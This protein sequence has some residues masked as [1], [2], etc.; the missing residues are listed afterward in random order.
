MGIY[1]KMLIVLLA[2]MLVLCLPMATAAAGHF[3]LRSADFTN[4]GVIPAVHGGLL[5]PCAASKTTKQTHK[6]LMPTLSWS[7]APTGTR[8]FALLMVDPDIGKQLLKTY[9]HGFIHW[10]AYNIPASTTSLGPS[11]PHNYTNGKNGAGLT[12][13]I[14]P[15][16][17]PKD[18]PHHYHFTLYALNLAHFPGKALTRDQ[19]VA[20]MA[21]HVLGTAKLVGIFI[22]H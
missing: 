1:K 12:M 15:C 17:S 21:G 16:A 22:V 13:Y 7:G 20:A 2:G 14:G 3:T 6:G 8:S 9:P 5:G 4:N 19:L 11:S 18:P 10:V